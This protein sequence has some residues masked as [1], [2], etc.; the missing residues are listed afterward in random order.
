MTT[1]QAKKLAN[2]FS[3]AELLVLLIGVSVSLLRTTHFDKT[4]FFFSNQF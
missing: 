1:M 3:I 4:E 2:Y